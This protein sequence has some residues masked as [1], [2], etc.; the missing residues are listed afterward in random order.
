MRKVNSVPDELVSSGAALMPEATTRPA[1]KA[2]GEPPSPPMPKETPA[3][4]E[5]DPARRGRSLFA[6]TMFPMLQ[7]AKEEMPMT[8]VGKKK[9]TEVTVDMPADETIRRLAVVEKRQKDV[10]QASIMCQFAIFIMTALALGAMLWWWS[11]VAVPITEMEARNTPHC[12]LQFCKH[13][14]TAL[15]ESDLK[16][17]DLADTVEIDSG[18]GC[19][20]WGHPV[21]GENNTGKPMILTISQVGR[22]KRAS[23]RRRWTRGSGDPAGPAATPAYCMPDLK[24]RP[25]LCWATTPREGPAV[26]ECNREPSSDA[27]PNVCVL[28]IKDQL[29]MC[30]NIMRVPS[31]EEPVWRVEETEDDT[32]VDDHWNRWLAESE[33]GQDGDEVYIE[34]GAPWSGWFGPG[35]ERSYP[36]NWTLGYD[37]Y[38]WP[39]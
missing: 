38:D 16:A 15:A 23:G 25:R 7:R 13:F 37:F 6:A 5:S 36:G 32:E 31:K 33:R 9:M 26:L 39:E 27:N 12:P 11:M 1:L 17:E 14:W 19:A 21:F 28:M 24:A 4:G 20:C 29:R 22:W 2:E 34:M 8:E 10:A 35:K 18:M 3:T 30:T